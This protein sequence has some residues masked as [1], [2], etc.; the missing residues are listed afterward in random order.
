MATT[1]DIE[2][3]ADAIKSAVSKYREL[4]E[5]RADV[6]NNRLQ[7]KTAMGNRDYSNFVRI[8]DT[9]RAAI[10]MLVMADLDA[11]IAELKQ[12]LDITE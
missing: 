11:Q 1:K 7:I 12:K 8:T 2:A 3:Q 5:R 6:A 10:A 4:V 9:T